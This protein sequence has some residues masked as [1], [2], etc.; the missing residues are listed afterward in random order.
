[1]FF[2]DG[3][4]TLVV[5]GWRDQAGECEHFS[6]DNWISYI[7]SHSRFGVLKSNKKWIGPVKWIRPIPGIRDKTIP[8]HFIFP[9]NATFVGTSSFRAT[10]AK[11]HFLNTF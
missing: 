10:V 4:S 6:F 8:L 5:F 3:R 11:V 1:M 2:L 9:T 7:L